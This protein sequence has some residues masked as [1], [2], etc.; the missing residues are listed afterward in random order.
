MGP[1]ELANYFD[2]KARPF[3]SEQGFALVNDPKVV[4]GPYQCSLAEYKSTAGLFL[5]VGFDPLDGRSAGILC[6][7]KWRY[8]RISPE[9]SGGERLSNSYYL[10]ADRFGF[11]LPRSYE[12]RP[13]DAA[14]RAIDVIADDLKATLP[15]VIDNVTLDD[16]VAIE[17]EKFGCQWIETQYGEQ[18]GWTKLEK[19]SAFP[20]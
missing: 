19:I 9:L 5:S 6:G 16:L 15:A 20:E 8:A 3:L 2:E 12:V 14:I 10:L 7:R 17:S 13:G 1:H 4:I 18:P 11:E